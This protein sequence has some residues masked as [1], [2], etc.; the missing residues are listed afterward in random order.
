[1]FRWPGRDPVCLPAKYRH[2]ALL[3]VPEVDCHLSSRLGDPWRL[4]NSGH[5]YSNPASERQENHLDLQ[6]LLFHSA[7]PKVSRRQFRKGLPMLTMYLHQRV[8]LQA[9]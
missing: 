4:I 5:R 3:N 2:K 7:S 8:L 9:R 6:R 1:L